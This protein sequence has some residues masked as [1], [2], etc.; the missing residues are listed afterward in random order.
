MHST[1]K[2]VGQGRLSPSE[3]SGDFRFDSVYRWAASSILGLSGAID[4]GTKR[5]VENHFINQV[6]NLLQD[7]GQKHPP[8]NLEPLWAARRVVE[9]REE[10]IEDDGLLT[11]VPSGFRITLRPS[12]P[13]RR[14]LTL[15]HEISHTFFYDISTSP[16]TALYNHLMSRPWVEEDLC[17]QMG[18]EML[19]PSVQFTEFAHEQNLL[20]P[21]FDSLIELANGF[22]VAIQPAVK[23]IQDLN[24]WDALFIFSRVDRNG[25]D[26]D[27][28]RMSKV[29][30]SGACRIRLLGAAIGHSPEFVTHLGQVRQ[31]KSAHCTLRVKKA[32]YDFEVESRLWDTE[33]VSICSPLTLSLRKLA[34]G[35]S[36]D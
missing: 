18:R 10:E 6:R 19:M 20:T 4:D 21:S 5:L 17:R 28:R 25:V 32:P 16:P 27:L 13:R 12:H 30:G 3:N 8:I 11:S 26:D 2:G 31:N 7:C 36:P 34:K 14:R 15:A 29:I 9:V 33:I 22:D 24:L 23:R 35:V 1:E